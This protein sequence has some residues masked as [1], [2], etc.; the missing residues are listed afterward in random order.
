M[1]MEPT[2][3]KCDWDFDSGRLPLDFVNTSHWHAG[4]DPIECLNT[5]ADLIR[6]SLEGEVLTA[7]DARLLMEEAERRPEAATAALDAAIRLREAAYRIF[8]AAAA[9][10]EPPPKDIELLNTMLAQ[11]LSRAR[12]EPST[13][14]FTLDWS[15]EERRMDRVLWPILHLTADLL[16]SQDLERVGECADERG[17]GYLFYD[18]S[19]NHNRR[20]CSMDSCGN[21]AKAR[22]HYARQKVRS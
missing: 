19:R 15:N 16:T 5:Y 8:S 2:E 1:P 11:A 10:A 4:P 21:R 20:W 18:T 9:R 6:W 3:R 22:R 7:Q 14:G 13:R 17:C 12:V